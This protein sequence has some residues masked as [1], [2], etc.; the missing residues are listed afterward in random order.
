M[1]DDCT[2]L[3]ELNVRR[4]QLSQTNDITEVNN[5]YNKRRVEILQSR[6]NFTKV[7]PVYVEIPTPIKYSGI[8]I[9]G[10]SDEVGTIKITKAGFLY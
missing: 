1:F 7:N 8:P 2:T 5:A 4:I 6:V 9:A 3:Q 10:R